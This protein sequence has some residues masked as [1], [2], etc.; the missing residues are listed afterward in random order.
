MMQNMVLPKSPIGQTY[1]SRQLYQ[2]VFGVV[3]HR[4][5]GQNQRKEGIHLYTWLENENKKDSN[6]VAS[7]LQHYLG[8]AHNE[9]V[10]RFLL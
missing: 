10:L 6:M 1:Y 5:R 4:G 3:H 8:V 7:A 9:P 2:Y